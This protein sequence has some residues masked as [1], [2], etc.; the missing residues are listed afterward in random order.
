MRATTESM[1][2]AP[3]CFRLFSGD[4][5]ALPAIIQDTREKRPWRFSEGRPVVVAELPL[6]DYSIAGCEQVVAVERKSASDLLRSVIHERDRFVRELQGLERYS[7]ACIVVEDELPRVLTDPA[8]LRQINPAALLASLA[9]IS[10]DFGIPV[11]WTGDRGG[12]AAWTEA[13]LD[14]AC[15]VRATE[16][17]KG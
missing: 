17:P 5:S 2:P 1:L 15:G 8:L 13:W 6:G 4:R 9:T 16:K 11:Y 14:R 10:C 3:L 7:R 12:A